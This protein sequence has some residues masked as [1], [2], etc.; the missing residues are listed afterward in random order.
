MLRKFKYVRLKIRLSD[1]IN[2]GL[3]S[4]AFFMG[5]KK[6][7]II[8]RF[9]NASLSIDLEKIKNI[10]TIKGYIDTTSQTILIPE[11]L[12]QKIKNRIKDDST[13]KLTDYIYKII[14]LYEHLSSKELNDKINSI[15]ISALD[16]CIP[17]KKQEKVKTT[18]K[19]SILTDKEKLQLEK[20]RK[21]T[22]GKNIANIINKK[23]KNDN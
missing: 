10:E 2:D 6:M 19:I 8:R 4:F 22:K 20:F 12:I 11:E 1:R 5:Y 16:K 21:E 18:S 3:N 14:I 23:L 13:I 17:E 9:L 15:F 7:E